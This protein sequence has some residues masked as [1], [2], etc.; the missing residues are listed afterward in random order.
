MAYDNLYYNNNYETIKCL[1]KILKKIK[2]YSNEE[3]ENIWMTESNENL[4]TNV[5][6]IKDIIHKGKIHQKTEKIYLRNAVIQRVK[7]KLKKMIE[8][9]KIINN[10]EKDYVKTFIYNQ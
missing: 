10:F 3:L 8:N 9:E 1:K 5:G 4:L 2:H 6:K 7:P